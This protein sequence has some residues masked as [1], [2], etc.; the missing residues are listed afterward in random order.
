MPLGAGHK[1][2]TNVFQHRGLLFQLDCNQTERGKNGKHK[3]Y[4]T[5]KGRQGRRVTECSYLFLF[6]QNLSSLTTVMILLQK[7]HLRFA[8][9]LGIAGHTNHPTAGCIQTLLIRG[10]VP[11]EVPVLCYELEVSGSP[12]SVLPFLIYLFLAPPAVLSCWLWH[13]PVLANV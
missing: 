13:Q 2:L 1:N 3:A 11:E 9:C 6:D 10:S 8:A 4:R 5:E 12:C 7:Y